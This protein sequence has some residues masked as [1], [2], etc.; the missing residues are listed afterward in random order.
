VRPWQ[1]YTEAQITRCLELAE[2]LVQQ[3]RLQDVL[4]HEDIARGRKQDPGPAFPLAQIARRPLGR[5]DDTPVP[6]IVSIDGLNIRKGP[7]AGFDSV[8]PALAQGTL[9]RL[10][11]PGDRWSQ[12]EV[13]SGGD[14]QGW[15]NNRFIVR[16]K[17]APRSLV[18]RSR[19]VPPKEVKKTV[20]KK[21]PS[22]QPSPKGRGGKTR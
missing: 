22:P 14:V 6:Y 11:E 13:E 2:L 3:Y 21:T 10:V 1:V 4:G 19:A 17:D 9:L 16:L 15:V 7:D 5:T 8:A 12:V 20:K 18:A